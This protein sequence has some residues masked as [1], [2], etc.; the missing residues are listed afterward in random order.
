[1]LSSGSSRAQR[2]PDAI[3]VLSRSAGACSRRPRRPRAGLP[4]ASYGIEI[5]ALR[6]FGGTL[7][8]VRRQAMVELNGPSGCSCCPSR[9][10]HIHQRLGATF[11]FNDNPEQLVLAF[12]PSERSTFTPT[13]MAACILLT[14]RKRTS[15]WE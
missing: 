7:A 14:G 8:E 13:V 9:L 3:R 11:F 12:P 4:V 5:R 10:A 15:P 1:M 6:Y 2:A